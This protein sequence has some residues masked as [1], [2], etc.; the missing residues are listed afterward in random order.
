MKLLLVVM[1]AKL[2]GNYNASVHDLV[3]LDVTPLSLGIE[4]KSDDMSALIM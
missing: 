1:A 3:L 4:T 2:S